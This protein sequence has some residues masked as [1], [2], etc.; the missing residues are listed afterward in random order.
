[1]R[2]SMMEEKKECGQEIK[3]QV[4]DVDINL[5]VNY[6][7]IDKTLRCQG[8]FDEIKDQID[9][10]IEA[11]NSQASIGKTLESIIE[12]AKNFSLGAKLSEL[13]QKD[14]DS[15]KVLVD[16]LSD[17]LCLDSSLII[18][19]KQIDLGIV[20]DTE[21][22][23][24]AQ[25][26]TEISY[27][28]LED[29][30]VESTED[31]GN[32]LSDLPHLNSKDKK[33]AD[34]MVGLSIGTITA[35]KFDH[36][37]QKDQFINEIA[38]NPL[39]I[40][41]LGAYLALV[42]QGI[43]KLNK[44]DNI[45]E[46]VNYMFNF[47]LSALNID[48]KDEEH[49]LNYT[50]AFQENIYSL[51]ALIYSI[52]R[53]SK[54]RFQKANSRNTKVDIKN[55]TYG[56]RKEG[57][58]EEDK[59]KVHVN[60]A[61]FDKVGTELVPPPFK[62][63]TDGDLYRFM[64]NMALRHEIFDI[65]FG[66]TK[67]FGTILEELDHWQEKQGRAVAKQYELVELIDAGKANDSAAHSLVALGE[68]IKENAAYIT[69]LESWQGAFES[70][71]DKWLEDQIAYYNKKYA[72]NQNLLSVITKEVKEGIKKAKQQID[73]QAKQENKENKAGRK[74]KK[75]SPVIYLKEPIEVY[76]KL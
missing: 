17:V 74:L 36:L 5:A 42:E 65:Q 66:S 15:Y 19:E 31:S 62:V 28:E 45:I 6:L 22:F 67:R 1:M 2:W 21:N 14:I 30:I 13:Q 16:V 71:P 69:Q 38:Y 24:D 54:Y 63:N 43:I 10:S 32:D 9:F 56:I 39:G 11:I 48:N 34:E 27:D 40:N 58:D 26:Y 60:H 49:N 7:V 64:E 53:K 44:S 68:T 61:I 46:L 20:V 4:N 23:E 76:I 47:Y 72:D 18:G 70:N 59:V 51:N 75:A 8:I 55:R 57:M 25:Y 37:E 35:E 52:I 33:L 73:K 41:T 29:N 50:T 12:M 3:Q